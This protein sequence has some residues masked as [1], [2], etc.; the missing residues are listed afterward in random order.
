MKATTLLSIK[1]WLSKIHPPLPR[2]ARES[3][4]L[5]SV[6]T[7]SFQRQL[8]EA[9]PPIERR[10]RPSPSVS[11]SPV[12][13]LSPSTLNLADPS[14]MIT[15]GSTVS[16]PVALHARAI[17]KGANDL[18]TFTNLLNAQTAATQKSENI[19]AVSDMERY[20]ET[21]F[22]K[23]STTTRTTV[24]GNLSILW[25]L[26]K[27]LRERACR[28]MLWREVERLV[29]ESPEYVTYEE[30]VAISTCSNVLL[31]GCHPLS[32]RV[33]ATAFTR[34]LSIFQGRG[35]K[36]KSPDNTRGESMASFHPL[37]EP[38]AALVKFIIAHPNT[39]SLSAEHFDALLSISELWSNTLLLKKELVQAFHPSKPNPSAV[40]RALRDPR[41][42]LAYSS[43]LKELEARPRRLPP[44]MPLAKLSQ[45]L[46]KMNRSRDAE[47]VDSFLEAHFNGEDV[48]HLSERP[49][50]SE[51]AF[52]PANLRPT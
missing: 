39:H 49:R 25:T 35:Y 2:S 23:A 37:A 45:M 43:R 20:V 36:V 14:A 42:R 1:G 52:W 11:A 7:S 47:L 12:K 18:E 48:T 51:H 8:D 5:L 6:L 13:A 31:S 24:L 41:F 29:T 34:I 4:K 22:C 16:D 3:Q 38:A 40:L 27:M 19:E 33:A 46:Q 15:N 21:W 30:A 17:W 26:K 32:M 50:S 9:H 10:G 44:T 28:D